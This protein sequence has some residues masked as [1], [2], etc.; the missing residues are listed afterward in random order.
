[1]NVYHSSGWLRTVQTLVTAA[2]A[3][4]SG[5]AGLVLISVY[6]TPPTSNLVLP[7]LDQGS[8]AMVH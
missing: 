3:A 7:G 1:V 8:G 6:G 5:S 4:A 2:M